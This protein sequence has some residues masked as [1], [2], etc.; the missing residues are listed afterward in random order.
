VASDRT[1]NFVVAWQSYQQEGSTNRTWG[2]F[3]R[4]Y[5]ASG[6]PQG[7]E[8]QVNT[9]TVS[10]QYY[11]SVASDAAGNFVVAWTSYYQGILA[12]RYDSTGAP[13]G[14]EFQ[15]NTYTTGYQRSAR[16]ASG[17]AGD[18]VVVW[19]SGDGNSWGVF[20]QCYAAAGTPR[21]SEFQVNVYTTGNQGG[22]AVALD[23]AGN[24]IAAW[25]GAGPGDDRGVFARRLGCAG[26]MAL[27]VDPDASAGA[28][29]EAVLG[30]GSRWR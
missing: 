22:P 27:T 3:A 9:H 1:G 5:D 24:L 10:D 14:A 26:P 16:V 17:A 4:R 8:F 25:S 23:G 21:G 20:G 29:D 18:F 19:D 12:Q 6:A 11:P 13:R 7:A 28:A 2:V 15:V 30:P